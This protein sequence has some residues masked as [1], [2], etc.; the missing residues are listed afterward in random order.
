MKLQ[1]T[2]DYVVPLIPWWTLTTMHRVFGDRQSAALSDVLADP[3]LA[4]RDVIGLFCAVLEREGLDRHLRWFACWCVWQVAE[5]AAD[6]RVVETLRVAQRYARGRA[7]AEELAEAKDA[8]REA[9]GFY[10]RTEGASDT[11]WAVAMAASWAADKVAGGEMAAL[12]ARAAAQYVTG[13]AAKRVG[14]I[15]PSTATWIAARDKAGDMAEDSQRR[16]AIRI[17]RRIEGRVA[18]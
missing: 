16:M 10:H 3:G 7:S 17:A 11:V 1:I 4:Y 2:P 8:A 12:T 5:H 9:A 13:D 15:R 18:A 6:A 14:A